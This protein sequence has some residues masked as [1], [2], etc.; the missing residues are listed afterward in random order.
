MKTRL[1]QYRNMALALV[2]WATT[3]TGSELTVRGLHVMVPGREDLPLC[4]RFIREALPT[5]GVNTLVV[6]FGY[7]FQFRSH[8]EIGESWAMNRDDVRRLSRA[9][10]DVGVKLI[11]EMGCLG[12]Q[13]WKQHTGALLKK[14]PQF[15]EAPAA[16]NRPGFYCRSWC[17]QAPGLHEIVFDLLDEL[18][19]ACEA[20]AVHCGLD[21]VFILA[22]K[23][24]PRCR[25]KDPA[26]LFASE[27]TKL[28][29]HLKSKG[30]TMW[31]WGDRFLDG[32]ATDIGEWEASN[33]GTHPA[34]NKVPKDIVICDWHYDKAWP[35]PEFF[36][37][38]GFKVIACPWRKSHVALAQLK[39]IRE[40]K[41]AG[42]L[43]TTWGNWPVFA[44]AYFGEGAKPPR[45]A[46]ESLAC[47]RALYAALKGESK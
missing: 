8:P 43:Q 25:G 41:G 19:D 35:T 29:D 16:T 45:D 23:D 27:V 21:E 11:P 34:V 33:I 39:L 7:S 28:H 17:P 13:S 14:Y 18:A 40:T 6:E 9:C 47:F 1:E 22:D 12:H 5:E 15:D 4:E 46:A 3:A 26:E 38:K 36:A 20:D 30:R 44:R 42:M 31:M 2:V 37:K 24:C 32:K 10:R